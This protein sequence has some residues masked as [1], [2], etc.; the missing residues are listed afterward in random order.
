ML[1]A[2]TWGYDFLHQRCG[3]KLSKQ[4]Y[5]EGKVI[6]QSLCLEY[7]QFDFAHGA[8][9]SQK[10]DLRLACMSHTRFLHGPRC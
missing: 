3:L 8:A 4:T 6:I 7:K 1:L 5:I 10:A 2:W 9:S